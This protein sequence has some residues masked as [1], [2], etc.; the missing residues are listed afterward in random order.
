T[1][2]LT[3]IAKSAMNGGE[4]G[5]DYEGSCYVADGCL[6]NPYGTTMDSGMGGRGGMNGMGGHGWM[7]G[8]ES[9]DE[10][11][12]GA[13]QD[14]RMP[15]KGMRP[16]KGQGMPGGAA[17]QDGMPKGAAP[18]DGQTTQTLPGMTGGQSI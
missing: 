6:V 5:I 14:G 11:A 2:G 13:P 18:L 12:P 16:Q 4:G 17:P 9:S 15:M 10:A 7:N 8:S 3:T 1:G